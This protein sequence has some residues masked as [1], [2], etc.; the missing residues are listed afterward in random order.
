MLTIDCD[1]VEVEFS[2]SL[3]FS[4]LKDDLEMGCFLVSLKSN[5]II[6]I[7]KLHNFSQVG[8][9]NS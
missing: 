6:I 5:A 1:E 4:I 3:S 7:C 8:N 2:G 9:A